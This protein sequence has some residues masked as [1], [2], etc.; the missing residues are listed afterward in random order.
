MN[1]KFYI[2]VRKALADRSEAKDSTKV[3]QMQTQS[4]PSVDDL[5]KYHR[6]TD[7]L[8]PKIWQIFDQ[9]KVTVQT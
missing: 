6:N 3:P 1:M 5:P 2:E 9:S 7:D 4:V 8:A